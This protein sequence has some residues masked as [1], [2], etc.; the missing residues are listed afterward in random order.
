M[1]ILLEEFRKGQE[2]YLIKLQDIH[3]TKL[4][5]SGASAD[6]YYGTY[7]E[8]PVAIK[9]LKKLNNNASENTLKEFKRELSTLIRVR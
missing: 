1:K 5:G 3:I 2:Y 6:V 9:K 8:T 4:I 7:K